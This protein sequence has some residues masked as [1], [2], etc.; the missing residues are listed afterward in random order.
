MVTGYMDVLLAGFLFLSFLLVWFPLTRR[1]SCVLLLVTYVIAVIAERVQPLGLGWLALTAL[2][3]YLLRNGKPFWL[4]VAAYVC[5]ALISLG[6]MAHQLPGFHNMLV[7]NGV[8]F[9]PDAVPFKMYLN[10]DKTFPSFLLMFALGRQWQA[11]DLSRSAKAWIL[12][13]LVTSAVCLGAGLIL[14]AINWAPKWPPQAWLWVMNNLLLVAMGE[15]VFFRGYLQETIGHAIF[16]RKRVWL[17]VLLTSVV[18]GFAHIGGGPLM[19][20]VSAVAGIGYGMAFLQG[21]IRASVLTHFCLNLIH[22]TLFTYPML[23]G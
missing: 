4:R 18:F 9:T 6:L 17:S 12:W 7:I 22:F 16:G 14:G 21:G 11:M 1:A 10:L 8:Q 23:K 15:E 5:F 19:V 3:F 13:L 20:A 2:F